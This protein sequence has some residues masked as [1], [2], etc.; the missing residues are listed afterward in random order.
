MES[1]LPEL[2][3]NSSIYKQMYELRLERI[4]ILQ[5]LNKSLGPLVM[6]TR[7]FSLTQPLTEWLQFNRTVFESKGGCYINLIADYLKR[8]SEEAEQK[9]L[10]IGLA[11]HQVC[12][13]HKISKQDLAYFREILDNNH[14]FS[15]IMQVEYPGIFE[16]IQDQVIEEELQSRPQSDFDKFLGLLQ[17]RVLGQEM[18]TAVVAS[19]LSSQQSG[20]EKNHNF[21]FVGPTGTGKT[22]LAKAIGTIKKAFISFQMNQYTSSSDSARFFGSPIGYVGSDSKPDLAQELDRCNPIKSKSSKG[23]EIYTVKNIVILFD[24]LEKAHSTT[25]QSFLTLFDEGVVD[26]SYTKRGEKGG[27]ANVKIQYQLKQSVII[28]TSNLFQR[29]IVHAFQRNCSSNEI[30]NMFKG[31]NVK[32][33]ESTKYSPEFLGRVAITPFGPVP[34]GIP[35]QNILKSKMNIFLEEYKKELG[36]HDIIIKEDARDLFYQSLEDILYGEGTDLRKVQLFLEEIRLAVNQKKNLCGTISNK[37]FT[38]YSDNGR[39]W[40]KI[41]IFLYEKY[42]DFPLEPILIR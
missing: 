19:A 41:T 35:Y 42:R 29:D 39:I 38:L 6:D 4:K 8:P 11:P 21:L 20:V 16:Q 36:C 18:A 32:S 12:G 1:D 5:I 7:D 13:E 34:R 3:V 25:R 37:E 24:E 10:D 30:V 9:L 15:D 17:T 2:R 23:K 26:I 31:L 14:K 40:A 27:S 33:F 28:A 22:E